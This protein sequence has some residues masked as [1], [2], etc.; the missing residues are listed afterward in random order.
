MLDV[1]IPD[2]TA[3]EQ[4]LARTTH[5]AISAHHDDIEIMAYDGIFQC[6]ES[7]KHF[8][9][10]VVVT[11]GSGSPRCGAY[12]NVSDEDMQKI[13]KEEQKKAATLGKYSAQVFLNYPS[14]AV[15]GSD[16]DVIEDLK[17]VIEKTRPQY[18]YTH[19]L[20]DKHDTHV[21]VV[22]RVIA[23]LRE[24][25]YRPDGFYGCEA[26][27]S[28]D[29]MNDEDKVAFNV[30]GRE[31]LEASLLR[32]FDSQ[33]AGG[34]RYDLATCGRRLANATFGDPYSVDQAS[35]VI[36]AMDLM[37][38]LDGQTDIAAYVLQQIDKFKEDV[39]HRLASLQP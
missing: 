23:A 29:W 3:E 22:L 6:F 25:G 13:R 14:A 30:S 19:N 28:L 33:V 4:A 11:N 15:K 9:T 17:T 16:R 18:I 1:F 5:L 8:F 26:W 38:L 21:G 39:R 27:R 36:Y 31:K 12:A 32:I 34:K 7:D 20:A 37:P 24:T 2:G 10:G 35:S